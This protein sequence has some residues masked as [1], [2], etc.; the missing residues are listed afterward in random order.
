ME[1]LNRLKQRIREVEYS[2]WFDKKEFGKVVII[3]SLA[4][5]VVS[6]HAIYTIDDAVEQASNSTERMQKTAALVGSDGFKQSMESLGG[7]GTTIQGESIDDVVTNLEYASESVDGVEQL[8]SELEQ[9]RTTYQWTALIGML[10]IVAG[11]TAIY[12]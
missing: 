1:Q 4:L 6:V 12:I 8:S 3:A 9:A 5:L 7:T 11:M 2:Y 10:G